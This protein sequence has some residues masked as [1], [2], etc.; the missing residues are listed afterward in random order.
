MSD[1]NSEIGN[2]TSAIEHLENSLRQSFVHSIP[3][4]DT[5]ASAIYMDNISRKSDSGFASSVQKP[6]TSSDDTGHT[7]MLGTKPKVPFAKTKSFDIES[8]SIAETL[9]LKDKGKLSFEMEGKCKGT[10]TQRNVSNK[11]DLQIKTAPKVHINTNKHV[12]KETMHD[13]NCSDQMRN[14]NQGVKV[15]PAT[16]DGVNSWIDY[17]SHFDMVAKVNN[18][19]LEQKGLYL[20]VSLRGQAQATLGDSMKT[21]VAMIF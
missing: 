5:Q 12:R 15:K 9:P 10:E 19:S 16:Y 11:G 13:D 6:N 1:I 18:W 7:I 2:L 21:G 8:F 3:K 17:K 20:A 4:P 14:C